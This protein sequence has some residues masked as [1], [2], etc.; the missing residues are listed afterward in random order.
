MVCILV[1]VA[2]AMLPPVGANVAGR[3]WHPYNMPS[4]RVINDIN[5]SA[6]VRAQ[7]GFWHFEDAERKLVI[8]PEPATAGDTFTVRYYAEHIINAGETG[9]D[10]IPDADLE[11]IVACALAELLDAEGNAAAF[12]P[13]YQE[14]L[15]RVS[16]KNVTGMVSNQSESL[17]GRVSLKYGS[18]GMAFAF[19]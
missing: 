11:L 16:F 18:G 8:W 3:F 19:P 10:T 14:G 13:D 15:E 7:S 1:T 9:Y 17:R 6:S 2:N 12:S 4:Q 5:Q